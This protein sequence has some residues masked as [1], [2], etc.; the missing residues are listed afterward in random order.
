MHDEGKSD[1]THG[2]ASQRP[3]RTLIDQVN[4]AR[5]RVQGA[6][7]TLAR[8]GAAQALPRTESCWRRCMSRVKRRRPGA[9]GCYASANSHSYANR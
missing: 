6:V 7:Q 2:G 8:V 5:G 9:M 1:A 3:R 4:R